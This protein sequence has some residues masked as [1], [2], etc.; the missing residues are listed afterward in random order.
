MLKKH[1]F[2]LISITL[3]SV[4]YACVFEVELPPDITPEMV[5]SDDQDVAIRLHDYFVEKYAD[6]NAPGLDV[7]VLWT[8]DGEVLEDTKESQ[9]FVDSN[10]ITFIRGTGWS[11]NEWNDHI[12]WHLYHIRND[13][14]GWYGVYAVAKKLVGPP[15]FN[16]NVT[17]Y[18]HNYSY[19]YYDPAT[20]SIFIP[21]ISSDNYKGMLTHEMMHAFQHRC[22]PDWSH[23]SEGFAKSCEVIIQSDFAVEEDEG[24]FHE[25]PGSFNYD[26][27]GL[28]DISCIWKKFWN[29]EQWSSL[30]YLAF[31]RYETC[32]FCWFKM[33]LEDGLYDNSWDFYSDFNWWLRYYYDHIS[34]NPPSYDELKLMADDSYTPPTIEGK[35]YID[36]FNSQ[37]I[38]IN[39]LP[40]GEKWV[41]DQYISN[42]Y[43]VVP[44]IAYTSYYNIGEDPVTDKFIRL[45]VFDYQ[46]NKIDDFEE[47]TD[48]YGTAVFGD[49]YASQGQRLCLLFNDGLGHTMIIFVASCRG[50]FSDKEFFGIT[51]PGNTGVVEIST[52]GPTIITTVDRG[53]FDVNKFLGSAGR[54]KYHMVYKIGQSIICER[55]V[56]KDGAFLFTLMC[57][58]PVESCP[59]ELK[60]KMSDLTNG[61]PVQFNNSIEKP[62]KLSIKVYP[63]PVYDTANI[64]I[65]TAVNIDNNYNAKIELYDMSGRLINTIVENF[66]IS[67]NIIS[68]DTSNLSPGVYF[69]RLVCGENS[70][71][72]P[73]IRC[74]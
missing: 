22:I 63:N 7:I 35:S 38:L 28:D 73:L 51:Y 20:R 55:D 27:V 10:E 25:N 59:Q 53:Y 44:F 30:S 16:I 54:G 11:D 48:E 31:Y 14:Q 72:Q 62:E 69:I 15:L 8:K 26:V 41:V 18:K 4:S 1:L 64:E 49:I 61:K 58:Q 57:E 9:N 43:G 50:N 32:G 17:I 47:T 19:G 45:S 56:D 3:F 2:K 36:W 13:G 60:D 74:K 42:G 52:G 65:I 23:F 34:H 67:N 68:F 21:G 39:W 66:V 29:G 12:L 33:W 6:F 5:F 37:P 40:E 24:L 70:I 71:V 46:F